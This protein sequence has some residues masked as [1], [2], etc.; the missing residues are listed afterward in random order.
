VRGLTYANSYG[1]DNTGGEKNLSP[2][3]PSSLFRNLGEEEVSSPPD[4]HFS[5]PEDEQNKFQTMGNVFPSLV[6]DVK[7]RIPQGILQKEF[8]KGF[9]GNLFSKVSPEA[10]HLLSKPKTGVGRGTSHHPIFIPLTVGV[11]LPY[12]FSLPTKEKLVKESRYSS[13]GSP[14]MQ[15]TNRVQMV[16]TSFP[17]F[18]RRV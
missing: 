14:N 13:S 3:T 9:G 18:Y 11:F 17:K 7:I 10:E 2:G 12:N 6:P 16:Q 15:R 1:A 5:V 4:P 8:R